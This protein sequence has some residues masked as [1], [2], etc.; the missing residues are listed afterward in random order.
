M[1]RRKYSRGS[2]P[3]KYRLYKASGKAMFGTAE[4]VDWML[5]FKRTK[6]AE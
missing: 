3:P 2:T 4:F 5:G 6:I 1:T